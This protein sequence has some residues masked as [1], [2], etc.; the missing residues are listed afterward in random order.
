M[1]VM[2]HIEGDT[3]EKAFALPKGVREKTAQLVFGD[4]RGPNVMLS[5]DKVFLIEIDWAGKVNEVQYPLNL[6]RSVKW[7]KEAEELE[8]KYIFMHHDLFMLG[9]LFPK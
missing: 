6:S 4:L 3:A 5:G 8:M 7:A 9:Q 2:E 1:V